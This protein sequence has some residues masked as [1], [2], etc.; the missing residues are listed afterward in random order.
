VQVVL[1]GHC[2]FEEERLQRLRNVEK[3]GMDVHEVVE[4]STRLGMLSCKT[5]VFLEA[6]E[7][8]KDAV[9]I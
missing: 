3:G 2:N 4:A 8:Y 5:G 6:L 9:G 1:N 7:Y